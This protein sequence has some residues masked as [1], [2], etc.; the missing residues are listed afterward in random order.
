GSPAAAMAVLPPGLGA[1]GA[2]MLLAVLSAASAR[3]DHLAAR[4]HELGRYPA[5]SW[6]IALALFVYLAW[7][8]YNFLASTP[9]E[10]MWDRALKIPIALLLV[11]PAVFGDQRDGAL[12]RM[13]KAAPVAYLGLVS[14][15]IYLWHARITAHIA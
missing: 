12:R 6:A 11:L 3:D 8:P 7:R 2:G 9:S 15:G 4:T 14:Y 10:L 13:L 5:V 1:L